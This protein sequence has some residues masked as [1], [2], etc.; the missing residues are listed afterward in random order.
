[1]KKLTL[2][3]DADD[4]LLDFGKAENNAINAIISKYNLTNYDNMDKAF[5]FIN[6]KMWKLFEQGKIEREDI[7]W[8]RFEM[9]FEEFSVVG[10]NSRELGEEY[11]YHLANQGIMLNGAKQWLDNVVQKHELFCV[12]NGIGFTQ[13]CRFAIAGIDKYFSKVFISER[14]G[15]RKPQKE[16][17]DIVK[18][19]IPYYDSRSTY[20]IGDSLT[21]DILGGK[22]SGIP[23]IWFNHKQDCNNTNIQPDY[24]VNNYEQLS[25]LVEKLARQ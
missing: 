3:V 19:Q 23:A 24:E 20:I 7:A 11:K 9:L 18:Q 5:S 2:L 6:N 1:M 15:A 25:L 17:F 8:K 12:T 13:D 22:N 16:F 10:H 4:T 14:L 21:S